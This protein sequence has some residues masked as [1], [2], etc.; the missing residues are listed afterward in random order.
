MW[1]GLEINQNS[2]YTLLELLNVGNIMRALCLSLIPSIGYFV[3]IKLTSK[4]KAQSNLI[5]IIFL[6]FLFFSISVNAENKNTKATSSAEEFNVID[7]E[8]PTIKVKI[9]IDNAMTCWNCIDAKVLE[10]IRDL[11]LNNANLD[12]EMFFCAKVRTKNYLAEFKKELNLDFD[13]VYDPDALY[14]AKYNIKILP[15]IVIENEKGEIVIKEELKDFN[16]Y[17]SNIKEIDANISPDEAEQ[18]LKGL[19]L[20]KKII[21]HNRDGNIYKAPMYYEIY[22][23]PEKKIYNCKS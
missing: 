12:F 15:A 5:K 22:F 20:S 4:K 16:K 3:S 14:P 18:K 23:S 10:Q 7:F 19:K 6:L 1:V 11:K 2:Q 8:K 21:L 9:F 17:I 13:F